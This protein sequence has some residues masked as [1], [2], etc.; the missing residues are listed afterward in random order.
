MKAMA[1]SPDKR[2][3]SADDMLADLEEFRK[4]PNIS[5]DYT[6]AD[7]LVSGEDE[8]TH[9]LGANPAK[10]AAQRA[11]HPERR[12]DQRRR[13]EQRRRRVEEEDE[14]DYVEEGG[15]KRFLVITVAAI[16]CLVGVG[17]FLWKTI[18]GS[19]FRP[20]DTFTVPDLVTGG[21]T[22]EEAMALPEIVESG[23]V[24][25]EGRRVTHETAAAGTIV[26]QEPAAGS[27]VKSAGKTITVEISLGDGGLVLEDYY[28]QD[29]RVA[30]AAL[31][32]MGLHVEVQQT[33]S[34]DISA[35]H[36]ISQSPAKGE[37]V[38]AGSTV[39]L[40][41]S[42]G[43]D[44]KQVPMVSVLGLSV[45][46]ATK[47]IEG[48]KLRLGPVEPVASEEYP[49]G[50]ICYQSTPP[51]TS[52]PEGTVINLRVSTGPAIALPPD[53]SDPV[54]SVEPTPTPP[55][56]PVTR[57]GT[58]DLPSEPETVT[59]RVT[60]GGVEQYNKP[61]DT[62]MRRITYTIEG[63]GSQQVVVYIDDVEVKSYTEDFGS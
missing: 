20:A 41:V 15:G 30:E 62:R 57:Q 5:F 37:R 24:I 59:V 11:G 32:A 60:V 10:V 61:A 12:E 23:F 14:D 54:E 48:L 2:Y 42:L 56:V 55:P 49:A 45:A 16:L 25:E 34:S 63:T 40:V 27:E 51:L 3:L 13:E 7:L 21:Y 9:V 26:G 8:P 38:E 52:V 36:V 43:P 17:F 35:G 28:N 50:Q 31:T 33:N 39:V 47:M 1:S 18:F 22:L 53:A 19:M 4:N 46:D 6:P 44:V 58:V 29:R